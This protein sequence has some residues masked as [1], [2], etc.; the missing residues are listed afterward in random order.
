MSV[1]SVCK[2]NI[3]RTAPGLQCMG[4]CSKSF[5]GQCCDLSKDQLQLIVSQQLDWFCKSCRSKKRRSSTLPQTPTLLISSPSLPA[6]D[7]ADNNNVMVY[8][9]QIRTDISDFRTQQTE[10][11]AQQLEI[12]QAMTFVSN[13]YD[14]IVE[15]LNSFEKRFS[16]LNKVVKENESLKRT[17]REQSARITALEQQPLNKCIEI[18][19]I[20]ESSEEHLS[21]VIKT[22]ST[23]IEYNFNE[24]DVQYIERAKWSPKDKPKNIIVCFNGKNSRDLFLS[25]KKNKSLP[26][27]ILGNNIRP[28]TKIYINELLCKANKKLLFET[29]IFAKNNNFQFVWV[30]DGSIYIRKAENMNYFLI[31]DITDLEKLKPIM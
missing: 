18:I 30:R 26:T 14:V 23:A 21:D 25:K 3:K 20:P 13:S 15:K 7:A 12:S 10:F 8:L 1:C 6:T 27:T 22:I 24:N 31:N 17:V 4:E 28:N 9:K 16:D 29:K 5:H 2:T 11:K 19:G